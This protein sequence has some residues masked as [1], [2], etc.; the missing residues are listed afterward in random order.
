MFRDVS[1]ERW[2]ERDFTMKVS[3]PG[4]HGYRLVGRLERPTFGTRACALFAHCFTC[5]KDLQA[6]GHISRALAEQG[7]AV[8]RFDFTGLGE[9]EGDF[10]NTDF[11]S[12][13]K[14]LVAVATIGAPSNTEHLSRA[15]LRQAPELATQDEVEVQLAGRPFRIRRELLDDLDEHRL[16][17]AIR[18]LGRAL[19]VFHSP[20]DDT[21]DIEHAGRIYEDGRQ[22]FY[23]DDSSLTFQQLL[24][25]R[26]ARRLSSLPETRGSMLL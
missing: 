26:R 14:D 15:L 7:I 19:L 18:S 2:E 10:A 24:H 6:V 11:S 16:Q 20:V 17:P 12:N 1:T 5:S 9:S 25:G 4:P 3:F 8:L 22:R 21:V 23:S 13:L